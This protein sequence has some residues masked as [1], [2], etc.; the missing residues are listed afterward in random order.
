MARR[1][2]WATWVLGLHTC[3]LAGCLHTEPKKVGPDGGQHPPAGEVPAP[4][5]SPRSPYAMRTTPIPLV[6][7]KRDVD[8][9]Q[10]PVENEITRTSQSN[11]VKPAEPPAGQPAQANQP[12]PFPAPPD[13]VSTRSAAAPEPILLTALRSVLA[14]KPSEAFDALQS[15]DKRTQDLLL[16]LLPLAAR[17]SEGG[18]DQASPQENA[19]LIDQL[20]TLS[21][22]LRGRTALAIDK[23]CFARRIE[24]FGVYDPM[25]TNPI[26]LPAA[27]GQHGDR[28]PV[29]AEVKNFL[30]K[31]DGKLY[32][33]QLTGRLEVYTAEGQF[34]WGRNYSNGPTCTLSSRQDFY[35]SFRF[36]PPPNLRPG[37][38]L[39]VVEVRDENVP[40]A[41]MQPRV[42]R[43]KLPFRIG[44]AAP[45]RVGEK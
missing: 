16:A 43:C 7:P 30:S 24:G 20:N 23:A 12:P 26:F 35:V 11:D 3:V 8:L 37:N 36:S 9:H 17:L 4:G 33:I 22:L 2:G 1:Y 15:Y 45:A 41:D 25:P 18:L 5:E 40:T 10:T 13:L 32:E 14:K 38:Y 19:A 29:Y 42:A 21:N 27:D 31:F 6:E 44:D 34:V 39:L 28:A